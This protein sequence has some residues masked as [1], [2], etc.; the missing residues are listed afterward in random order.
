MSTEAALL[1]GSLAARFDQSDPL[2]IFPTQFFVADP[3]ICYLDGN[4]LGRLP[5]ATREAIHRF[6]DGE[7]GSEL[8]AG[9]SHWIDEAERVGDLLAS[10]A[11]GTGPGQTLV[12]DTTSMNLYQLLGALI[13]YQPHRKTIVVDS[14]NFPT[15]RYVV[16]GLA[17]AWGLNLITLDTDGS[18]GPG[19]VPVATDN[20]MLTA[21]ALEPYLN[22]DVAVLTLQSVNYRSGARPDAK[23]I[24]ALARSRGIPVVWDA[25]HAVGSVALRFDE[26]EVDFA[27]GCTYKYLNSGPGSPAWLFVRSQW[28]DILQVPIQGWFAQAD[29]FAMGPVFERVEGIRGFQVASPSIVGLR[30]VATSLE[31]LGRAG[32]DAIEAKA[33]RGTEMMVDL[34]DHWLVPLGFELLTPRDSGRRGG[35]ITIA[36]PEARE[37]AHA[38]R[39]VAGVIP[40][41]REPSS[42]RLAI[43]PLAT[44]YT[45]VWEGMR[46]LRDLVESKAYR[47]VAP[48]QG[49][50]T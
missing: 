2:R 25:A 47:S 27:V 46:R 1:D 22:D 26:N 35:H 49:R 24:T 6:V 17:R 32:I 29:Q 13:H 50:V 28:Q 34:V 39:V 3:D 21:E 36:H 7:W 42:I 11:L 38:M 5:L 45:E 23:A 44:T 10:V 43:S 41:Y 20:E 40:D 16:Q 31:M 14:S 15:D 33:A 48:A 19:A 37:I 30:G 8:V 12:A 4:S 9:W 18:G